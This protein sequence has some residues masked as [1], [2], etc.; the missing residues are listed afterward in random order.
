[1]GFSLAGC[2]SGSGTTVRQLPNIPIHATYRNKDGLKVGYDSKG[3][4]DVEVD[5]RSGK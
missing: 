5:Q 3:G 4:L 1:M 2:G